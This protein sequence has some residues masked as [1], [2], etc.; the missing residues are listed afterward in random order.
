MN[1]GVSIVGFSL[2]FILAARAG[3]SSTGAV[4]SN[5]HQS[6]RCRYMTVSLPGGKL[7]PGRELAH[8][9]AN[10]LCSTRTLETSQACRRACTIRSAHKTGNE[11][12]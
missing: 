12:L 6:L 11:T 3:P 8:P 9:T 10:V 5:P 4:T 7:F 1:I 2:P